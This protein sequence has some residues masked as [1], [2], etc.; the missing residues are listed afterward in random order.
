M[1]YAR[2]DDQSSHHTVQMG[3]ER[4]FGIVFAIVFCLIGVEKIIMGGG[5]PRWWALAIACIFLLLSYLQ[6]ALLRP[7][8]KLWF[9]FGMLLGKIVSPIAMGVIYYLTVTP[10]GLIMRLFGIDLLRIQAK[11]NRHKTSLWIERVNDEENA[12]SMNNQF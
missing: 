4:S 2:N 10:V 3:S 9:A 1:N 11:K 7:L 5:Y 12:D 6:P 8:N